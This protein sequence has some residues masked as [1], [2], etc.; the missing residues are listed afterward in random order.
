MLKVNLSFPNYCTPSSEF[1]AI[2]SNWEIS[3]YIGSAFRFSFSFEYRSGIWLRQRNHN[4]PRDQQGR[5][6]L[7]NSSFSP[8]VV[9]AIVVVV[10][11]ARNTLMFLSYL[12]SSC[13]CSCRSIK[14]SLGARQRLAR[15]TTTILYR[16]GLITFRSWLLSLNRISTNRTPALPPFDFCV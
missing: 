13:S 14:R 8:F 6:T 5:V 3:E 16:R 7:T 11:S 12:L 4:R 9:F 2:T 15:A 10:V 1:I